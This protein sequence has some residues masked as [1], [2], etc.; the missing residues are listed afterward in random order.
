MVERY[1]FSWLVLSCVL[2]A[3]LAMSHKARALPSPTA[4]VETQACGAEV[5]L[6]A[7]PVMACQGS[8]A[9]TA[10]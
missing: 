9:R 4:Q 3:G 5:L 8:F 7:E 1:I 2:F 10:D 6:T